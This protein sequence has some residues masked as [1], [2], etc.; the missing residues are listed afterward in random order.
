MESGATLRSRAIVTGS[1]GLVRSSA[2]LKL[3]ALAWQVLAIDNDQ[4]KRFFGESGFT[5]S[6][7][8]S[9]A[10]DKQY[11]HYDVDIRHS[12]YLA[13][14]FN[15]GAE[16]IIHCA[17]QPSHDWATANIEEDFSI[18]ALA[19]LHLLKLWEAYCPKAPFIH[20][21]TSKVYGDNPNRLP[22]V[23]ND[24]RWDLPTYHELWHGIPE[25]FSVD[26]CLHSFFGV[27]K[28]SGD[29]LAQ[30]YGRHFD[31]P[32]GIFRPGCITGANHKGVELH[33]F[34]SYLMQCVASGKKYTVYG[35]KGKQVR[36]NVHADDLVEAFLLFASRPKPGAVYNVGGRGLDCSMQEAIAACEQ[37]CGRTA[38]TEYKALTEY[39][40]EP[41]SG[42][43]QWWIS[44]ARKL[45]TDYGWRPRRSL[46]DILD[47][48]YEGAKGVQERAARLE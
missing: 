45:K 21:S 28:L 46:P 17:A 34:L 9:L 32:V 15:R 29:L 41:R 36:C 39:R 3:L 4:R 44:D 47:E 14:V 16:L 18:N 40:E 11:L 30:E 23:E 2:T 37:R 33:G 8:H 31:M 1:C 5:A 43:H 10:K 7:A 42:D 22:L 19:T 25:T 24:T 27:S 13:D 38:L 35:Y 20:V 6:M 26:S 12:V 48:L